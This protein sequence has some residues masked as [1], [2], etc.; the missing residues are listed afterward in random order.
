MVIPD[1]VRL[2]QQK[3]LNVS[4]WARGTSF[5]QGLVLSFQNKLTESSFALEEQCTLPVLCYKEIYQI[6]LQSQSSDSQWKILST[7]SQFSHLSLQ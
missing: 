3:S 4:D 6:S 7:V 1:H 5:W 2:Q